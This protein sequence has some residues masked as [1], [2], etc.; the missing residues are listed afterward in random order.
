MNAFTPSL[1]DTGDRPQKNNRS[2]SRFP[3]MPL[4]MGL[5]LIGFTFAAIVFGMKTGIGTMI[6]VYGQPAAIRDIVITGAHDTEITI[7]DAQSGEII[8]HFAPTE[9]GF[10]RGSLRA[11]SRMRLVAEQPETLPYRLIRWE[12]GS[13]SLSDTA[14]GERLYLNAFGPDNAAAY[15]ELLASRGNEKP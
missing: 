11:L 15:A 2:K 13:V 10:V 8:R 4:V 9:G 14:T 12:N 6:N 1:S 7:T 5:G 3:R